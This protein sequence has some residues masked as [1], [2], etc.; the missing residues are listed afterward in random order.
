M[1][2]VYLL[3][4]ADGTYYTGATTDPERRLRE[5]NAGQGGAYTRGRGPVQMV[6]REVHPTRSSALKRE[7]EIKRWP[8]VRKARLRAPQ[9]Y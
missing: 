3:A 7:A 8:R 4:C 2:Y 6:F 9:T 5:H 1:W